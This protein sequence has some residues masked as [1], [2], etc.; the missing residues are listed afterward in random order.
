MSASCRLSVWHIAGREVESGDR[1]KAS[2][3]FQTLLDELEACDV[4]VFG[5]RSSKSQL[6]DARR[7]EGALIFKRA[8]D[9]QIIQPRLLRQFGKAM[10]LITM[11]VDPESNQT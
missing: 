11:P 4:Y 6:D 3:A 7:R 8:D 2:Q 10:C 1:E 5:A 9:P